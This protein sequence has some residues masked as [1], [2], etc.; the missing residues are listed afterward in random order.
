M[1]W[2]KS[3]G[4]LQGLAVILASITCASAGEALETSQLPVR[5]EKPWSMS[6]GGLIPKLPGL[7]VHYNFSPHYSLGIHGSFIPLGSFTLGMSGRYYFSSDDGSPYLETNALFGYGWDKVGYVSP[8]DDYK[9]MA[10]IML[11]WEYRSTEGLVFNLAAGMSSNPFVSPSFLFPS[12]DI[13]LG[14]AF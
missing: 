11:G 5:E 6:F 4:V 14:F 8:Y 13:S 9:L 7:D 10:N 3:V 2:L 1:D 12:L